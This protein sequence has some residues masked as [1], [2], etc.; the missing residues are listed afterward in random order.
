VIG[1]APGSLKY[2]KL[3]KLPSTLEAAD[4]LAEKINP[5]IL[6]AAFVAEAARQNVEVVK[7]DL[8]PEV[9]IAATAA[10]TVQDIGHQG[11]TDQFQIVG[12]IDI[13]LYEAGAV[14]S[15]V[16]EAKQTESQRRI[17]IISAG[18]D[19]RELVVSSWNFLIAARE[20]I[21]A[22]KSQ[23]SANQLALEGVRQEYLVGSRT[24]LDGLVFGLP[25]AARDLVDAFWPGGLTIVVEH[26]SSLQ[27]D[28]GSNDGTVAVRMPLHPVAL[29]VLRETGPM[30]VSSANKAG[31]PVP[32]TAEEAREQLGYSVSVY[33][34]SPILSDTATSTVV[35]VTNDAVKVIRAGAITIEA[36]RDV[37][38]S[39]QAPE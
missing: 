29:E 12:S 17:E 28:L 32:V 13:P 10:K 5:N 27:W 24:T 6:A 7:G 31:Q 18:R 39:V 3:P 4:A 21:V 25:A 15:A 33:L 11:K 36:I 35:D 22:A 20:T 2:P 16:R 37:V 14:Y 30:A 26:A 19:V 9:S 34:D 1:H 23:V 38:P 8:L